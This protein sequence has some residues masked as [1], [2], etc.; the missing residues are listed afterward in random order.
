MAGQPRQSSR[1][2]TDQLQ[3]CPLQSYTRM[4]TL[5]MPYHFRWAWGSDDPPVSASVCRV[6]QS[7]PTTRRLKSQA[8]LAAYQ[9]SDIYPI[10]PICTRKSACQPRLCA[11]S[12]RDLLP[13][14]Q[15]PAAAR[16]APSINS[17]TV[18]PSLTEFTVETHEPAAPVQGYIFTRIGWICSFSPSG[19]SLDSTPSRRERQS[20]EPQGNSM[21]SSSN[22]EG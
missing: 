18:V 12:V 14:G 17:P 8:I 22:G 15:A 11:S 7:I 3:A 13:Q 16:T 5:H 2:F 10:R 1:L 20:A 9:F 19:I 6:D 21:S 4:C